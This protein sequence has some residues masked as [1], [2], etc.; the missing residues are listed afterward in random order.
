M[1]PAA[2]SSRRELVALTAIAVLGLAVH[3]WFALGADAL[4]TDRSIVLLMARRFAEGDLSPYFWQQN[5]MGALEPLLLAPLALV[6]WASPAAAA[7]VGVLIT[8]ALA[9]LSVALARRLEGLAWLALLFWAI[10]PA[11]V[12]HHHVAL[13]G[14]R[15]T[16]T[17][18]VAAALLIALRARSR[19]A[20][21]LAG[22]LAG[23]AYFGDH[24]M[25]AW[26]LGAMW[27]AARRGELARFA[28]GALPVVAL[29]TIAAVL[30]PAIHLAGP[31]DPSAWLANVP[32]LFGATLPQ[33]FGLLL[34]RAPGPL[35]EPATSLVPGGRAWLA[36]ALPGLVALGALVATL[37]RRWRPL[38]AGGESERGLALE[39][40]LLVIAATLGLFALV[41]GGGDRW[42]VRYLVPLWPAISVLAAVAAGQWRP[43]VRALAAVAVLPAAFTLFAD[44]SWP[45]GGDAD[46]ARAEAAAVRDAVARAGVG[47]VWADYWDAYRMAL[48][49]GESPPWVTLRI[50]Q[51]LPDQASAAERAGPVGY[52]LRRGDREVADSL[53]RAE[54]RGVIRVRSS[55]EVGRYRLIVA[56][57]SVPGL[58]LI[59]SD[60]SRTWQRIAAA[61]A[62][63]LFAGALAG[64]AL[65]ARW[66]SARAM[67]AGLTS[68]R[69]AA[70]AASRSTA[71]SP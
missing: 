38:R 43:R 39:A 33:L 69:G 6:G 65:L 32:L 58:V 35:F 29:D 53:A 56:D 55:E 31:N 71:G 44:R 26:G 59:T 17:L 41:G 67:R 62:G 37:A 22:A 54:Q 50:I 14:A 9:G 70:A 19:G 8:A 23:L 64:V 46:E 15:L 42:P 1:S 10:P 49:N 21:L 57:R 20:W 3:G 24:L 48:H 2:A 28:M 45:R 4:D 36:L 68:G 52:L 40:L 66:W 13:Y 61:G 27:V 16:A 25:I 11:V 34:G 18:L 5:Y 60:P 63:L 51:R 12:A 47:A 7:V 30:T